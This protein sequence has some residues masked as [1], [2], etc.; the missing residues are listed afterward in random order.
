VEEAAAA[1]ESLMEQAD[2]LNNTMA[3]F[4]VDEVQVEDSEPMLLVGNG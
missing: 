1:A 3:V 4:N 2:E